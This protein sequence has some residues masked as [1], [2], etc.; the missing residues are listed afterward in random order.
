MKQTLFREKYPVFT[1]EVEKDETTFG[2]VD[3]IIAFFK[4][5]IDTH[6]TARYIA[7]FDHYAHTKS[8]EGGVISDDILAAKNLVFCFGPQLPN[9]QVM[10]LRPRS[11][12]VTELKDR[13][14]VNFMEAPMVAANIAME[15]W[16][17]AIKNK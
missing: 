12:G 11:I 4:E 8:L 17:R 2:S 3:E 5:K 6:R 10:A 1:L 14:V 13:F 15:E 9:P 7:I 16:A